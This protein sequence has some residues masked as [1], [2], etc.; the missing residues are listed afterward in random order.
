MVLG[1][2]SRYKHLSPLSLALKPS[3]KKSCNI[4]TGR[5]QSL[6]LADKDLAVCLAEFVWGIGTSLLFH[7]DWSERR[8]NFM[9]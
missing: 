7:A 1:L 9:S 5:E 6:V 2:A 4:P 8:H 3:S